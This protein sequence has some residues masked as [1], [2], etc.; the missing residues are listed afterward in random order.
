MKYVLDSSV[1]LKFV[2]PEVDSAKAL[3]LRDGYRQGVH[4]LLSPDI[5][6]P[7][8]ANGLASAERQKRIKAGEATVFLHDLIVN[9]P[10]I[11]LSLPLLPR[12]VELSIT[13]ARPST[14]ASFSRS[15]N[16]RIANW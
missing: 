15:R 7:E 12:A 5:Y 4:D 1:G 2:L 8:V 10:K 6:P 16:E 11:H 9:S 3:R 14:I 13:I